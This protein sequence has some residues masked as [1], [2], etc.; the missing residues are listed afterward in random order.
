MKYILSFLVVVFS[1]VAYGE[2][3]T[4][5]V[6]YEE[7]NSSDTA[8]YGEFDIDELLE[9]LNEEGGFVWGGETTIK[10]EDIKKNLTI[11]NQ[12]NVPMID[13]IYKVPSINLAK[14]VEEK[15][16][17]PL[18]VSFSEIEGV[19]HVY[20]ASKKGEAKIT[21]QFI[22]DTEYSNALS[23]VKKIVGFTKNKIL[24]KGLEEPIIMKSMDVSIN[25]TELAKFKANLL[26]TA[27]VKRCQE[28]GKDV[29]INKELVDGK[30]LQECVDLLKAD[31]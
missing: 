23:L 5:Y 1:V 17:R 3:N 25:Y 15:I 28:K 9:K 26:L 29:G 19:D 4:E 13:I 24:P 10:F 30:F 16:S 27:F 20:S 12:D 22:E 2:E 11:K 7:S 8:V 31:N 6:T 18:E 21:V 14:D